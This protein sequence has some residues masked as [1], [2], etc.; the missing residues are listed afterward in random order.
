MDPRENGILFERKISDMLRNMNI[1]EMILD[2][3]TIVKIYGKTM[4]G[5]DHMTVLG[6]Y[7]LTFQDKW[8]ST[9]P[10][11]TP[12]TNIIKEILERKNIRTIKSAKE[13]N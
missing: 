7:I 5:I 4:N 1:F 12:S 3:R 6:D 11:K 10:H 8:E 13:A 9:T 2:E